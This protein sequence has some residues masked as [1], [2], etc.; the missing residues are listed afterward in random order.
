M[1]IV[2]KSKES[3]APVILSTTA[4]PVEDSAPTNTPATFKSL[5]YISRVSSSSHNDYVLSGLN[6]D[7]CTISPTTEVD[8]SEFPRL[9]RQVGFS[10]NAQIRLTNSKA[11]TEIINLPLGP[12]GGQA[13][14]VGPIGRVP[15]S[16]SEYSYNIVKAIADAVL[17]NQIVSLTAPFHRQHAGIIP[18]H[19]LTGHLWKSANYNPINGRRFALITPR[20]VVGC[21]HYADDIQVGMVLQFLDADNVAHSTVVSHRWNIY[22]SGIFM[23]TA[24]YML[25]TPM[26]SQ[27][28]PFP[29]VGPWY[30]QIT[31]QTSDTITYLPQAYGLA[32]WGNDGHFGVIS[33]Q[34]VDRNFID[35]SQWEDVA[36]ISMNATNTH[37]GHN[38]T[39]GWY[40]EHPEFASNLVGGKFYHNIRGGDSSSAMVVPVINGWAL[41]G[42]AWGV[43]SFSESVWNALLAEFCSRAGVS[44][45]HTITV[46]SSPI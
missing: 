25:A 27:I 36:G 37:L 5:T 14:A 32:L 15:G 21:G 38:L 11:T 44:P 41:A 7:G 16:Y 29:V 19:H 4:I 17:D 22:K 46:A 35:S 20:I 8:A 31:S 10:G 43:A 23:D 34:A 18:H 12:T 9:K 13:S 39:S 42:V 24:F 3:F 2:Q 40:N 1:R 45:A 33:P 30:Y 26:P 6:L 28:K